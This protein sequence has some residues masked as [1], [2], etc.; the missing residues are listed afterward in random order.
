VFE[1]AKSLIL[2]S[3]YFQGD[4]LGIYLGFGGFVSFRFLK[5]KMSMGVLK[6]YTLQSTQ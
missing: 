1:M 3:G 4:I 2:P 5:R 6:D